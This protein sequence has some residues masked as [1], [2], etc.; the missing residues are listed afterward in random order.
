MLL[1]PHVLNGPWCRAIW[2][3]LEPST[4]SCWVDLKR[5]RD[6]PCQHCLFRVAWFL[7][8]CRSCISAADFGFLCLVSK[9]RVTLCRALPRIVLRCSYIFTLSRYLIRWGCAWVMESGLF[10]IPIRVLRRGEMECRLIVCKVGHRCTILVLALKPDF[11][12]RLFEQLCCRYDIGVL[13]SL[14]NKNA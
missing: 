5:V 11:A 10:T 4:D 7:E 2:R 13:M 6:P 14:L 1:D 3:I 8:V 9:G 12:V